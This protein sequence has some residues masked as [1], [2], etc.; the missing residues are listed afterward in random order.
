VPIP[1]CD[2]DVITDER[3]LRSLKG[4]ELRPGVSPEV[5]DLVP[6]LDS[7]IGDLIPDA[8]ADVIGPP[9]LKPFPGPSNL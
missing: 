1:V 3:G 4:K 2:P 7:I 8:A 9:K 5:E 6:D